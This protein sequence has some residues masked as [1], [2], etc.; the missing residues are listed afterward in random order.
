MIEEE[1]GKTPLEDGLY[2]CGIWPFERS[3]HWG[4]MISMSRYY[5]QTNLVYFRLVVVNVLGNEHVSGIHT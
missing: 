2:F 3:S 5:D 1:R 4:L